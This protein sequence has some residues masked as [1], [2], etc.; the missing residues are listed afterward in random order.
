MIPK[1][2]WVKYELQRS[3]KKAIAER[4]NCYGYGKVAYE[5]C[6]LWLS[7]D[8]I[9]LWTYWQG[10]QLKDIDKK[11]VDILLASQD[12]GNPFCER[13]DEL[14]KRIKEIQAGKEARYTTNSPTD[15]TMAEMFKA[16]SEDI[17]IMSSIPKMRLFFTNY[18][19]G[20]RTGSE[21]S[22]MTEKLMGMDKEYFD[23][24]VLA[25]HP[26]IIICL[27]KITYE[28][29]SGENTKDFEK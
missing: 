18:S 24:L 9:N 21:S 23:N 8:Q 4:N 14:C 25:I 13:N 10:Y 6:E 16:F 3:R 12:W 28:M 20:Y 2:E 29:A 22:G 7:G 5:P 17:D 19:L 26:K 1:Q 15:R 11:G 27:G